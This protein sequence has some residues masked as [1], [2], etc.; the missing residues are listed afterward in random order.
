V[1]EEV[2]RTLADMLRREVRDPRLKPVTI[3]HVRMS[4]D[5]S[6]AWVEYSMLGA[7]PDDP[8]QREILTEAAGDLRGPL[9]RALRLRVA[10]VLHFEPDRHLAQ[11]AQLDALISRAVREDSARHVDDDPSTGVG[12]GEAAPKPGRG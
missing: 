10:P 12:D 4:P 7:D 5:L 9:G 1:A 8:L 3:T 6:H 11:S 2:Q